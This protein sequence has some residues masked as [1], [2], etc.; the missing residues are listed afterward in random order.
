MINAQSLEA[1]G[2]K[3]S[4]GGGTAIKADKL[5]IVIAQRAELDRKKDP[6]A[7]EVPDCLADEFLVVSD[8]VEVASVDQAYTEFKGTPNDLVWA[9]K[10][11]AKL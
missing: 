4:D 5:A 11:Q 3:V 9:G 1:I 6:F 2:E 10:W 8:S 7:R